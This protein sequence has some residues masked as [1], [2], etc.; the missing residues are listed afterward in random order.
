MAT[1]LSIAAYRM[2]SS[3]SDSHGSRN[4]IQ[5]LERLQQSVQNQAVG[6]NE[7]RAFK[8]EPSNHPTTEGS[9]SDAEVHVTVESAGDMGDEANT[10]VGDSEE[11][12]TEIGPIQSDS[13]PP[14]DV[15]PIGLL[16]KLSITNSARR[17]RSK[18]RQGSQGAAGSKD[19]SGKGSMDGFES[20]DD[21][22]VVSLFSGD[23]S[24]D[25]MINQSIYRVSQTRLISC[26]AL[27]QI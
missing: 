2:A 20:E 10:A 16:A 9:E 23:C 13:L 18:T 1:P 27:Q 4:V 5:W 12:K 11:G 15:V 7:A 24:A 6:T 21:D 8:F 25:I 22:N 19:G 3:P 14:D 17:G 26:Q